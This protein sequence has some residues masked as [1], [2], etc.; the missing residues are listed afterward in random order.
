MQSCSAST[1]PG[2]GVRCSSVSKN[3][4]GLIGVKVSVGCPVSAQVIHNA[5][6]RRDDDGMERAVFYVLAYEK[7]L[8]EHRKQQVIQPC[9]VGVRKICIRAVGKS[10]EEFEFGRVVENPWK[11]CATEIRRAS[12]AQERVR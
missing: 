12:S 4:S 5:I 2:Q 3:R 9:V 7:C 11:S 10:A 8:V 1:D 6:P